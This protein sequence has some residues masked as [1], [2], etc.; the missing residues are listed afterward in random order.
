VDRYEDLLQELARL[1][2]CDGIICGHIHTPEDKQVGGI[3]YLNSGDWV[4][5]LTA[6][7]EHHDGRMELVRYR[8]FIARQE[9][10][11]QKPAGD[12]RL[13]RAV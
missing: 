9:A 7:I 3:H 11:Y 4:E 5:S 12:R 13:A 10:V 6:I 8:D 1:R 2:K